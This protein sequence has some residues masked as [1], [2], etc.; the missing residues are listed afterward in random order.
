MSK[1]H[2]MW[3][4]T[5]GKCRKMCVVFA[6]ACLFSFPITEAS[7][8]WFVNRL[9][10]GGS[11]EIFFVCLFVLSTYQSDI[12]EAAETH[13]SG[14]DR[15]VL[16]RSRPQCGPGSILCSLIGAICLT[17]ACHALRL[18]C[19]PRAHLISPKTTWVLSS[20]MLSH[21]VHVFAIKDATAAPS[22]LL[23]FFKRTSSCAK[24]ANT[25]FSQPLQWN[26]FDN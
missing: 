13:N 6:A 22:L 8:G 1:R 7:F 9:L 17:N 15:R 2:R 5:C 23:L 26:S 12:S 11:R 25:H 3:L 19:A 18:E 4:W 21:C 14:F 20:L 10:Q 24:A 16:K